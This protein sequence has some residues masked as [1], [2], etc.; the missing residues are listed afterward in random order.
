M[1]TAAR[2]L[3]LLSA[4]AGLACL[5]W[6]GAQEWPAL[7]PLSS[8]AFLATFILSRYYPAFGWAPF[9]AAAYVY[10]VL[11]LAARG[12]FVPAYHAIWLA[13]L[14]GAILAG[15]RPLRWHL[16]EAWRLPLV[17][18]ALVIALAWPVLAWR[19]MSFDWATLFDF[20]LANSGL[21]GPPPVVIASMLT[22]TLTEL[23]GILWF[24]A[25]FARFAATDAG[26]FRRVVIAPLAAGLLMGAALAIYQWTVDI[27]F[28]S[29][30][31]WPYYG[32]AAGGLLDGNAFGAVLGMWSAA[33]LSF[34]LT[35]AP[36]LFA[37]GIAA[38]LA[39]WAGVWATGSRMAL[40]AALVGVTLIA[41]TGLRGRRSG[42]N[43]RRV[44][45]A[46]G[47]I[48]VAAALL[49]A[50]GRVG[51]HARM[52]MD[53]ISRVT[54]SLPAPNREALAK[55]V[56]FEFWNRFG[57]FGT[58][59]MQMLKDSPVVGVGTGTFEVLFPDY[60]YALTDGATRGHFDNA[61]SWYRHRLAELGFLGS[62]GWIAW[63]AAFGAFVWT[64]APAR[65][66]LSE[67][68]GVKA[69]LVALAVISLVSMP[70]RDP[71][72]ALTF[73]IF[74]FWLVK[75]THEPAASGRLVAFSR[76]RSAWALLWVLALAFAGGTA[77]VAHAQ[78]QPP[79]RA[80]MADW[81]YVKGVSRP[82]RT[83]DGIRRYAGEQGV[84]VFAARPG[85]L[86]LIFQVPHEDASTNPV[87][88]RIFDRNSLQ[89]NLLIS[90]GEAHTLYVRVPEG[91][92]RMMI[93]TSVNRIAPASNDQ[94][95]RGLILHNWTF[96]RKPPDDAMI[97]GV[98]TVSPPPRNP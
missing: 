57:P 27:A 3:V 19:E 43:R 42:S 48:V 22:V 36:V 54:A 92:D 9:L 97:G 60:A 47:A 7:V 86:R 98:P 8:V 30:H 69:G 31:Q 90:D 15:P 32:R 25:M 87:R 67:S 49:M 11:F 44:I 29:D 55:F 34:A 85:F 95:A 52:G 68:T 72:V 70:T 93:R 51:A 65:E 13:A 89:A 58:A 24:D 20:S 73:W 38:A 16:P 74:A 18:W 81:N 82:I 94:A 21:G 26:A 61:Q 17:F 5:T 12:A 78:L 45:A 35:S 1:A 77:W 79:Y 75:T 76:T 41:W 2:G 53:P 63:L 37:G 62:L 84:A 56:E 83:P 10:P 50:L 88:V 6:L 23:M 39:L 4:S 66:G 59:S 96:V 71:F 80:I 40:L 28:L 91:Q 46:L 33:A 14:M 64:A